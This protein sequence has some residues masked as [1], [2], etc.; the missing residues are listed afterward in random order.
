[1]RNLKGAVKDC[2]TKA[3]EITA[4]FREYN[5]EESL[6]KLANEGMDPKNP[7]PT[8]KGLMEKLN[9]VKESAMVVKQKATAD[10]EIQ[11][12]ATTRLDQVRSSA[13]DLLEGDSVRPT[14]EGISKEVKMAVRF[15]VSEIEAALQ[16]K[17]ARSGKKE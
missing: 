17:K 8:F 4:I 13:I 7:K 9:A 15:E 3:K 16:K 14:C 1:M 10:T 6:Y 12:V 2:P 5:N 11:A